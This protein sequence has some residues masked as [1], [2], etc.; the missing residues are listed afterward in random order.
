ML[1]HLVDFLNR[2]ESSDS[3]AGDGANAW[4]ELWK[5]RHNLVRGT[6]DCGRTIPMRNRVASVRGNVR[7]G[8]GHTCVWLKVR[9][10]PRRKPAAGMRAAIP[11]SSGGCKPQEEMLDGCAPG[12]NEAELAM[13]DA[14]KVELRCQN[15]NHQTP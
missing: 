2:C 6:S 3:I 9:T 14:P 5:R 8:V 7:K 1:R 15:R 10:N 4:H 13:R 11:R 12:I